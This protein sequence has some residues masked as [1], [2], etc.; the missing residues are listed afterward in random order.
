MRPLSIHLVLFLVLTLGLISARASGQAPDGPIP[1][2]EAVPVA[3]SREPLSMLYQKAVSG[4]VRVDVQ[5]AGGGK[6]LGSGFVL[7]KQGLIVTNYHV[8]RGAID[9]AVSFRDGTSQAIEGVLAYD[10]RQDIALLKINADGRELHVLKLALEK[11][12]VGAK[13][14]A[15]G[16]PLGFSDSMTDGII[17]GLRTGREIARVIRENEARWQGTEW[18]Q[19]SAPISPGNSGGPLLLMNGRVVGVNTMSHRVGQN[20]NFAASAGKVAELLAGADQRPTPLQNVTMKEFGKIPSREEIRQG[21]DGGKIEF[22]DGWKPKK[23]YGRSRI[24]QD[25]AAVLAG[26]RCRRCGGDGLVKVEVVTSE[27]G[28]L[29]FKNRKKGRP[30]TVSCP[31]CAG[32]G[33]NSSSATFV[34]LAHLAESMLLMKTKGMTPDVIKRTDEKAREAFRLVA[35]NRGSSAK[36]CDELASKPLYDDEKKKGERVA[37]YGYLLTKLS[38]GDSTICVVAAYRTAYQSYKLVIVRVQGEVPVPEN[39]WCLIA[40][41]TAGTVTITTRQGVLRKTGVEAYVVEMAR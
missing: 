26:V 25:I 15:I 24:V 3:P 27:P 18:I 40:G 41:L 22:E 14:A 6:G 20:I 23:R 29:M 21:Q 10:T 9:G 12:P 1:V 7:A 38:R 16:N 30:K 8:I 39:R 33:W 19:T 32:T 34:R 35:L 17:N 11:P 2:P 13:V 37:F 36:K 4:V 5:V 31:D 28:N